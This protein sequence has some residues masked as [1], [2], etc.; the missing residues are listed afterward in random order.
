MKH[1]PH[2]QVVIIVQARMG[3]SRLP[4]KPLKEVL[5]RPLLGYLLERLKR[6]KTASKVVVA[7]TTHERDLPLVALA[8]KN[9]VEVVR[10]SEEDVLSRYYLAGK[11]TGADVIVRITA[12][13]PLEDPEI[14]DQMVT[15]FVQAYP[16]IDYLSNTLK[17]TYPRGLDVEVFSFSALSKAARDAQGKDEKEHVTLYLYRH[18]ELFHLENVCYGENFSHYRW[19]VDTVEDFELIKKMIENVYPSHPLFTFEDLLR[20]AR[21]HPEW[22]QINKHIEQKPL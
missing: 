21:V 13:C 19:T 15:Q 12:D 3:A 16:K 6:C 22:E 8:K 1:G 14:I 11:Q 4:G 18:P 5:N 10:G 2:L 7:T 20:A 17:R 9:G